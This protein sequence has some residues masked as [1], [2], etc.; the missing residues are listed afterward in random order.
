MTLAII[1]LGSNLN[2]NNKTRFDNLKAAIK[3]IQKSNIIDV[4]KTSSVYL[5]DA[6][7]PDN[8]P[9]N[10]DLDYLNLCLLIQT[11]LKPQDLLKDLKSI[12]KA[13]GREQAKTWAPR[14]IDLDILLYSNFDNQFISKDLN[15]PHK[16]LFERPFA[17]MPAFEIIP[18]DMQSYFFSKKLDHVKNLINT[19]QAPNKAPFNTRKIPQKINSP[20][21]MQIINATPNSFSED[22]NLNNYQD[23]FKNIDQAISCGAH[24]IDI[25]AEATNPKASAI[26]NTDEWER[27]EP[28]LEYISSN[29]NKWSKQDIQISLDTRNYQTF[30]KALKYDCIDILNDVSG[31]TNPNMQNL[32]KDSQIKAV[33]MHSL[34]VP[35]KKDIILPLDK[36]PVEQVYNWGKLQLENLTNLGIK[37]ENLIF[38]PGI[39]FGKNSIQSLKLIQNL[40]R[41]KDLDIDLLLGHSR[42]SWLNQFVD[43]YKGR[44]KFGSKLE[45]APMLSDTQ[46]KDKLTMESSALVV[47][48]DILRVHNITMAL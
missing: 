40:S 26:K 39:G 29:K 28:V 30:E 20:Y 24:M 2:K 31:L 38:D 42:K 27:L 6:Q 19:W 15:I 4:I 32:V 18:E 10:W 9:K 5:S 21:L 37:K 14:V 47:D 33:Y 8:P 34:S 46:I 17:L 44:L 12:E 35:A 48:A 43:E 41:F 13:L 11:N 16:H 7:L 1:G 22:N 36:D 3:L 45:K 25:G 23:I